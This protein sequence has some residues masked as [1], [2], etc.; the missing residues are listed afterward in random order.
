MTLHEFIFI[1]AIKVA[2][3]DH[4]NVVAFVIQIMVRKPDPYINSIVDPEKISRGARLNR[5]LA[6][7][8]LVMPHTKLI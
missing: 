8:N 6:Q 3:K 4:R 2:G 7:L 1:D 5:E